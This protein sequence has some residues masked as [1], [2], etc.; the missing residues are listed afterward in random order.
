MAK[1]MVEKF[2]K[3][4]AV[5]HGVVGVSAMLDPRYKLNVLGFYFFRLFP[6]SYK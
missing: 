3:Y 1:R 5:I 4:W 2:D 6:M